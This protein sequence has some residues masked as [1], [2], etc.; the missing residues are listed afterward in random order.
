MHTLTF[1]SSVAGQTAI[2]YAFLIAAFAVAGRRSMAQLTLPDYFIVALVGSAVESGLYLGGGSFWAGLVSA[3]TLIAANRAVSAL[4]NRVPSVHRLL[5]GRPML[6]VHDGAFI[7]ANLR[8]ARLT[9]DNI[10]A[11]IRRRGY[12]GLESVRFAVLEP[13]GTISVVPRPRPEGQK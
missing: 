4:V 13:A 5:V 1:V 9:K 7:E 10:L 2:I 11:A 6:V 8:R 3:G 12:D